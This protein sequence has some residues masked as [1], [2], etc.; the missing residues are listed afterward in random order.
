V[1]YER[2]LV[3]R[4][5]GALP[6]VAALCEQLGLVEAVDRFCPIRPLAEYARAGSAGARL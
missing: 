1:D 2:D 4:T 6:V 3:V 5:A